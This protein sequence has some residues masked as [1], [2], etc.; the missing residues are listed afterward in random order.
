MHL[1]AR[2]QNK[3][4]VVYILTLVFFFLFLHTL[5]LQPHLDHT[6]QALL[7]TFYSSFI[8]LIQ[9]DLFIKITGLKLLFDI[10]FF[11]LMKFRIKT[12]FFN[13]IYFITLPFLIYD[14]FL[15]KSIQ[16]YHFRRHIGHHRHLHHPYIHFLLKLVQETFT[17]IFIYFNP[18]F[19]NNF[20]QSNLIHHFI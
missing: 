10:I 12:V 16:C 13:Q 15:M 14:R 3:D 20:H 7:G 1:I 18:S 19:L 5:T 8:L 11:C 6:F 4:C 17:I 2:E 9:V